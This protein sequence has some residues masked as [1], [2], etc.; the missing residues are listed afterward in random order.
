MTMDALEKATAYLNL[1]PHTAKEVTD[2]LLRKGYEAEESEAAVKQ[3]TD[4]GYIDDLSYARLYFEYGFEKGRGK[5][6]IA[7]ELAGKG[8]PRDVIDQ[9]YAEL[10]QKPDEHEMALAIA[11]QI[12]E[13][14][15]AE[16][17]AAIDDASEDSGRDFGR[18]RG[19][20]RGK[21]GGNGRKQNGNEVFPL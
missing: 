7:R 11:R 5:S 10:E 13:E 21:N 14:T 19:R 1:K 6:R 12:I 15:G 8:I 3:L 4:Y 18:I 20:E 2:Y 16:I 17:S 9:A